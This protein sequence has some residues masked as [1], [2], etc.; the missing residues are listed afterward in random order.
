MSYTTFELLTPSTRRALG[1]LLRLLERYVE[2]V[3]DQ[4]GVNAPTLI[5]SRIL[6]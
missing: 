1:R 3:K 5:R 4:E 2:Q 6:H